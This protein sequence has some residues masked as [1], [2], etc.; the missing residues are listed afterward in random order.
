MIDPNVV[1]IEGAPGIG[2]TVLAKEIAFQ[3][4]LSKL[5]TTKKLLFLV[6]LHECDINNLKS[7][8]DFMQ[9]IIKSK[10]IVPCLSEHIFL[11]QGKDVAIVHACL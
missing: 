9:H 2:K 8:E 10:K 6:F 4:S 5:L 11:T 7:I 3:W 1:L